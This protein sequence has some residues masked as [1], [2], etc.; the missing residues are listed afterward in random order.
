MRRAGARSRRWEAQRRSAPRFDASPPPRRWEG[1]VAV[2]YDTHVTLRFDSN[3][4]EEMEA[5]PACSSER[6][7]PRGETR[8][9]A[10]NAL[11][12]PRRAD[13]RP[14]AAASWPLL[15][16]RELRARGAAR[17]PRHTRR[18]VRC[19]FARCVSALAACPRALMRTP[20]RRAR[21]AG[22][23]RRARA[24][25]RPRREALTAASES[26]VQRA[27]ALVSMPQR[28]SCL[29]SPPPARCTRRR[30]PTRL[31]R[32][33]KMCRAQKAAQTG[34]A[35]ALQQRRLPASARCERRPR[36]LLPRPAAARSLTAS[37]GGFRLL[38]ER[39]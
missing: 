10:R 11:R 24:A 3:P 29:R 7:A 8:A 18:A 32:A 2:T 21:A 34:A 9:H 12:P 30:L 22:R 4:G 35:R 38:Q 5:R 27:S 15:R 36:R 19:F 33:R 1:Y 25:S 17:R 14:A 20:P 23:R 6:A 37:G 26:R 31:G 28:S 39:M 13:Q 16:R